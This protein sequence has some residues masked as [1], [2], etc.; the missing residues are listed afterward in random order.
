M[1]NKLIPWFKRP[2]ET[3]SFNYHFENWLANSSAI[4]KFFSIGL[5]LAYLILNKVTIQ[6]SSEGF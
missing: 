2:K 4:K 3:E 1:G 6:F 5:R